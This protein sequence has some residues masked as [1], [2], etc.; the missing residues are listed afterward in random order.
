M[1]VE[2]SD[3]LPHRL[4]AAISPRGDERVVICRLHVGTGDVVAVALDQLVQRQQTGADH[5]GR[6]PLSKVAR[7]ERIFLIVFT[8]CWR[9]YM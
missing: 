2:G 8:R 1:R 4:A 9:L 3:A 5:E 6:L 7:R